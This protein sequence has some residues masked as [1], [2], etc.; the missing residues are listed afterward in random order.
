MYSGNDIKIM[1]KELPFDN[2]EIR[3]ALKYVKHQDKIKVQKIN[4]YNIYWK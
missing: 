2:K 4:Q 1:L 3:K